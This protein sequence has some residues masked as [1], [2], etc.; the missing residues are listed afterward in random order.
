MTAQKPIYKKWHN[1][2]TTPL[3]TFGHCE[4]KFKPNDTNNMFV[5]KGDITLSDSNLR[6]IQNAILF[7]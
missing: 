2:I 1:S 6:L 3:H 7:I 5:F 4:V